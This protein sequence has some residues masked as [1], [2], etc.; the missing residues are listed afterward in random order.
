M[1]K[2]D[3]F[4]NILKYLKGDDVPDNILDPKFKAIADSEQG[5]SSNYFEKILDQNA[6]N[7]E[8]YQRLRKFMVDWYSSHRSLA[9]VGKQ[10]TDVFSLPDD[11]VHELIRSYGFNYPTDVLKYFTNKR[12]FF[13]DLVNLYKIKGTPESIIKVLTYYGFGEIDLGEYWLQKDSDSNLVF[14]GKYVTGTGSIILDKFGD[15]IPYDTMTGRDPH[16]FM[17]L[18]QA[19]AAIGRGKFGLPTKSPYF[20]L[21][22]KYDMSAIDQVFAGVMW[23]YQKDYATWASGTPLPKDIKIRE[24]NYM[25]SFLELYTAM[26]YTFNEH[27]QRDV[28]STDPMIV[29]YDGTATTFAEINDAYDSI[30]IN[31]ATRDQRKS[32]IDQYFRDFT[33]PR[34]TNPLEWR[35]NAGILLEQLNPDLKARLDGF[36]TTGRGLE[37]LG[38]LMREFDYWVQLNISAGAP[39]LSLIVLG[40]E[41]DLIEDVKQLVNFFKPYR[42]RLASVEILYVN[43]NPLLDSIRMDDLLMEHPTLYFDDYINWGK[44]CCTDPELQCPDLSDDSYYNRDTYDCGSYHDIG[45]SFDKRDCFIYIKD[46]IDDSRLVCR[47]GWDANQDAGYH[48]DSSSEID[49]VW[50]DG[51]WSDYDESGIYDC[52]TTMENV[53]IYIIDTPAPPPP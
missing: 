25:V 42:A 20:S 16:W 7:S 35:S 3:D 41:S 36:L 31:P 33:K 34:A 38:A 29:A 51:G 37:P 12:N 24:L 6:H 48:L 13:L 47:K 43:K 26:V 11:Y 22:P 9:T 52:L 28:G 39:F 50:V 23:K 8:D 4:F 17:T 53:Q 14:Q 27:F 2:I 10:S 45:A 1:F 15:P 5:I 21:R 32:L 18:A 30:M 19:E 46:E 40:L 44:P 49:Y